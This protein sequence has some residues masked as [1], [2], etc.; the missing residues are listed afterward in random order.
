[1][2]IDAASAGSKLLALSL[3]G[4]C[5]GSS[6]IV[7]WVFETYPRLGFLAVMVWTVLIFASDYVC[8]LVFLT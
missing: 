7:S 3:L 5:L 1:M 2:P 6:K 8:V 4:L